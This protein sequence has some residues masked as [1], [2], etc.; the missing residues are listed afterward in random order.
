M[1]KF[2]SN[3]DI[4]AVPEKQSHA[5][6]LYDANRWYKVAKTAI[7]SY[8][9]PN[10]WER[11]TAEDGSYYYE[12]GLGSNSVNG[13]TLKLGDTI[14]VAKHGNSLYNGLFVVNQLYVNNDPPDDD[15]PLTAVRAPGMDKSEDFVPGIKV[16]IQGGVND[17]WVT[18]ILKS[19]PGLT[20]DASPIIFEKDGGE[21]SGKVRQYTDVLTGDGST[22][23]FTLQIP[24]DVVSSVKTFDY[25]VDVYDT[26][27]GEPVYVD[28]ARGYNSTSHFNYVTFTFYAP[29]EVG[30]VFGVIIKIVEMPT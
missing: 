26:V 4:N 19:G 18:Y 1:P 30:E 10:M 12:C 23:Q 20:V 9:F 22:S 29:P 25:M 6:R 11:K 15:I 24:Y 5:A 13:E 16:Y 28:Y 2:Y 8:P 14:F 17:P 7:T 21:P 3:I 27:T